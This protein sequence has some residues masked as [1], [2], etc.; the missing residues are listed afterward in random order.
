MPGLGPGDRSL[1]ARQDRRGMVGERYA[2]RAVSRRDVA[3]VSSC[4]SDHRP[5]I[6]GFAPPCG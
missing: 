5:G 4:R 6:D 2:K 1:G 3:A